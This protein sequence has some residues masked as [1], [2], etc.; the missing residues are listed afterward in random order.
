M[1]R[2]VKIT[3]GIITVMA[4]MTAI[5]FS[6]W[7]LAD[8][9]TADIKNNSQSQEQIQFA[10]DLLY[11]TIRKQGMDSIQRFSTY[12]MIGT[13]H[14]AGMMGKMGNPWDWNKDKMAMRFSIGDFDGQVEVL[15]GAAK[16]F[17]AGIQSWDYYEKMS[18][19][20][21]TDVQDDNG[22]VFTIAAFHYFSELANRLSNAPFIRYAGQDQLRGQTI[23]KLF[24]SWANETTSQ[25][26]HYLLWIGKESGLIEAVEFTTRD[27]PQPAPTFM[28]GCLQFEDYRNIDGILVPFKQTAQIG[29]PK[30]ETDSY[31]HQ[32]LI[33]EFKWD[34]IPVSAIRPFAGLSPLGD[35]KL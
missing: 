34:G 32:L 19:T 14:W 21:Q 2:S 4:L 8:L 35:E 7:L 33:Q 13:D 18:N 15:E 12:E 20:Y 30:D 28:Y 5:S 29:R 25:Y 26:D 10:Q 23:E 17:V 22:K 3:L 24:V 6:D 16:G 9:R 1:K 31:V 27:N 11:E